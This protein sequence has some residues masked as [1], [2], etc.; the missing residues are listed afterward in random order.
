MCHSY[1]I[2]S[3]CNLDLSKIHEMLFNFNSIC[4][5]VES[6]SVSSLLIVSLSH[7]ISYR[8]TAVCIAHLLHRWSSSFTRSL[9]SWLAHYNGKLFFLSVKHC[10]SVFRICWSER[11]HA[12]K[13]KLQL[14]GGSSPPLPS[15][16]NCNVSAMKQRKI[17][18][19]WL[20]SSYSY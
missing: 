2:Q 5:E 3:S 16:R 1:P 20:L 19:C 6:R 12:V 14:D 7:W 8:H 18:W 10:S 17:F 9:C 13:D 4:S 15:P 11:M